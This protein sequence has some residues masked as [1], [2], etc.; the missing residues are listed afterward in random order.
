MIFI[1]MV[2][3][4]KYNSNKNHIFMYDS[5]RIAYDEYYATNLLDND[6]FYFSNVCLIRIIISKKKHVENN[7]KMLAPFYVKKNWK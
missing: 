3:K 7:F 6:R 5:D 2:P 1:E 4:M